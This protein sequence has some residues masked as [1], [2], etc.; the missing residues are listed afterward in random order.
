MP[1]PSL[2]EL[3]DPA[4]TVL[5]LQELQHGVVGADSALPGPAAAGREVGL[6]GNCARLATGA[7]AGGV[8]VVHTTAENL[9]GGFGVNRNAR[10][11]AGARSAGAANA[12]GT[13]SVQPLD[14]I[15]VG[16]GDL[17]L[18]RYHGLSPLTDG[19]L[20]ALLR[21][22]GITTIVLTGVSVNVAILNIV[23]DAVNRAYQV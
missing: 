8:R 11:F 21:N 15:G 18:P 5:V 9:P 20:D 22:E 14:E 10:L 4:H 23:F 16:D 3:V 6:V 17:V 7:R 13:H 2:A 19:P 1:A 12:P